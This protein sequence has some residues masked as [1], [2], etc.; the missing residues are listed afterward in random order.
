MNS[1]TNDLSQIQSIAFDLDDTLIDTTGLLVPMAAQRAC[2]TM[3]DQGLQTD[4][5]TCI[6][7]RTQLLKNFEAQN[8]F[9]E[10][11]KTF[12]QANIQSIAKSGFD[13]FYNPQVPDKLPLIANSFETL[14]Q[15]RQ[16]YRL[17]LVTAGIPETQIKKVRATGIEKFFTSIQFV[18]ISK[19]Q[20]KGEAFQ[21][22]LKVDQISNLNLLCVGNRLTD[23]IYYAEKMN[24]PSCLFIFG[25]HQNE[26]LAHPEIRPSFTISDLKELIEDLGL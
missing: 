19:N 4:L 10:L 2:E 12:N 17:H 25:E 8:I 23:E 7:T 18:D 26:N 13:I 20:N 11:V 22:I 5:Q 21:Q 24:C 9:T 6:A 14:N 3:I 16:K 1:F 15:L